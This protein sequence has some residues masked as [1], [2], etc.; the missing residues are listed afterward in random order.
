MFALRSLWKN[1]RVV[2]GT[3]N[4]IWR[5]TSPHSD[6]CTNDQ[7][8]PDLTGGASALVRTALVAGVHRIPRGRAY[9]GHLEEGRVCLQRSG[10]YSRGSRQVSKPSALELHQQLATALVLSEHVKM[11]GVGVGGQEV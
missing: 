3:R 11:H 8:A 9:L 4:S 1:P 6:Q 2:S 7:Q 5:K 10:S